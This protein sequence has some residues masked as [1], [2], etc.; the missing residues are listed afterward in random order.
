MKTQTTENTEYH[1]DS[2]KHLASVFSV[3]CPEPVEGLR[4]IYLGFL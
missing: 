3:A 2:Q 4:S 1:G